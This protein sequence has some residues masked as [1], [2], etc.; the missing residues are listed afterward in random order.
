MGRRCQS[1]L[2]YRVYENGASGV[3]PTKT[4]FVLHG[5]LGNKLNWRTF[6]QKLAAAR[7]EWRFVTIDHRGHGD[8]P[9]L[10]PPHTIDACADDLLRLADELQVEPDAVMGHS[11]GGKVWVLDSLPGSV[12]NDYA[13]RKV[14]AS[15]ERVLPVLKS[16]PL[17]I[18]SKKQLITDLTNK[19][20]S[21]GEA[22]WLTTNLKMISTNPETYT[23]KMSVPVIEELFQSFLA[24]D[25]WP[26]VE[27]TPEDTDIHFVQ[28]DR[29]R[30]WTPAVIERLNTLR[31]VKSNVHHY[32][33]PNSDHWVHIDNPDGLLQIMLDNLPH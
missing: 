14:T 2:A 11:F 5:I 10:T 28:A 22:Q 21:L 29:S 20:I 33:L 19:G 32:V 27:T 30:M 3:E 24:N 8:S 9:P 16:I 15:I 23:W 7:P 17:P 25:L 12:A 31:H 1:S 6:S 18:H 4:A 13:Y 26:V